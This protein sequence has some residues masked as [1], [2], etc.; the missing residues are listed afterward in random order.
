M[1]TAHLVALALAA[2]LVVTGLVVDARAGAERPEDLEPVVVALSPDARHAVVVAAPRADGRLRPTTARALVVDLTGERPPRL[3]PPRFAGLPDAGVWSA[4]GRWA[5][6][7]DLTR[8]R[9]HL[10]SFGTTTFHARLRFLQTTTAATLI[11]DTTTGELVRG[12]ARV[13]A[14]GWRH[15]D[16]LVAARPLLAGAW[17]LRDQEGHALRLTD[18]FEVSGYDA[19]R[20]L[21]ALGLDHRRLDALPGL[22]VADGARRWDGEGL[23]AADLDRGRWVWRGCADAD[24][25]SR[26]RP[27]RLERDGAAVELAAGARVVLEACTPD[28]LVVVDDEGLA[29][30]RLPGGAREVLLP[31][32]G[33]ER[34][35][36]R[37]VA[38][39]GRR[40]LVRRDDEAWRVDL[41]GPAAPLGPHEGAAALLG[42]H[43]VVDRRGR[44]PALRAADGAERAAVPWA[45]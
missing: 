5:A 16:E 2:P 17:E 29:R 19:G 42:D 41:D 26:E 24:A 4:D 7:H 1:R 15:P 45:R 28:A 10:P 3:L 22:L 18:S 33:A 6:V 37:W 8:G 20:P 12:P 25:P 36:V 44:W 14:P 40:L 30:V 13:V 21:V 31:P 38:P 39:G 27:A 23:V 32:A 35:A 43:V 34:L 9:M 11:Y